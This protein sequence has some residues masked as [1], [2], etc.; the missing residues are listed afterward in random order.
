MRILTF[1]RK[2]GFNSEFKGWNKLF[3]LL[4]I[5]HV[6]WELEEIAYM[7][8]VRKLKKASKTV[9]SPRIEL[10]SRV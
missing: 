8:Y 7:I 9:V 5:V 4:K 1:V 2:I 3:Y 6:S 10:G